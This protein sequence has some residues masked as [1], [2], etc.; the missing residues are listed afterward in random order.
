MKTNAKYKLYGRTFK[1]GDANVKPEEGKKTHN[2]IY[3]QEQQ[4]FTR[5]LNQY[6]AK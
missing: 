1:K 4:D 6:Y 5:V 3:V 2:M